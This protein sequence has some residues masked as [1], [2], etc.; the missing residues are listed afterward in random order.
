MLASWVIL[1]DS[2]S[3]LRAQHL[4]RQLRAIYTEPVHNSFA[5]PRDQ[6]RHITDVKPVILHGIRVYI[7]IYARGTDLLEMDA[8][9]PGVFN[10]SRWIN[11]DLEETIWPSTLRDIAILDSSLRNSLWDLDHGEDISIMGSV[12]MDFTNSIR[13]WSLTGNYDLLMP[14]NFDSVSA[15]VDGARICGRTTRLSLLR[16]ANAPDRPLSLTNEP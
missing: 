12:S 6:R 15:R 10:G 2:W 16:V 13:E 8:Q 11:C 5:S 1:L 4:P 14:D 7:S 3:P 9:E